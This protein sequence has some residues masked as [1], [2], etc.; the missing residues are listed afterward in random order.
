MPLCACRPDS[1]RLP[2]PIRQD[3]G[4]GAAALL[5]LPSLRIQVELW[6]METESLRQAPSLFNIEFSIENDPLPA[7]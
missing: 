7:S 5:D 1:V 4:V 6:F 3:R 2:T